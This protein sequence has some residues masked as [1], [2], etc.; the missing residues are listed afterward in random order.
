MLSV[1]IY[2]TLS[3]SLSLSLSPLV[4]GGTSYSELVLLTNDRKGSFNLSLEC[5]I[6][7]S[8]ISVI[9]PVKGRVQVR[10]SF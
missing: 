2:L 9:L 5:T 1:V 3:F 8:D 6:Q 7:H 4:S 10:Y